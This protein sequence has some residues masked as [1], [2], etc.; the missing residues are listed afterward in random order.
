MKKLTTLKEFLKLKSKLI[1]ILNLKNII[2]MKI[3][4]Y[5]FN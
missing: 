1:K 2:M 4:S 5:L 3:K